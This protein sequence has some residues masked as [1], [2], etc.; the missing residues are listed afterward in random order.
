LASMVIGISEES[1]L[2]V[3]ENAT[4][5]FGSFISDVGGAA[6]LILGMNILGLI[7]LAKKS[8]SFILGFKYEVLSNVTF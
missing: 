1:N 3:A 4:Y 8:Y 6:G 7:K 2:I 5:P